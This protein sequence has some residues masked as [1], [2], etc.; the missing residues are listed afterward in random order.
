MDLE[1]QRSPCPDT[2]CQQLV[3]WARLIV[4]PEHKTAT[5]LQLQ[6]RTL[7]LAL[8]HAVYIARAGSVGR[9]KVRDEA[10]RRSTHESR[11]MPVEPVVRPRMSPWSVC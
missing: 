2:Y 11:K 1:P 7:A 5:F 8:V 9:V 3:I 6:R 4:H 10:S